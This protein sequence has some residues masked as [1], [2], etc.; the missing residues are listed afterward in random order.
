MAYINQFFAAA[1][2][3]AL[4]RVMYEAIIPGWDGVATGQLPADAPEISPAFAEFAQLQHR[5]TARQDWSTS[6]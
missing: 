5:M 6:T 4:S 3:F 2:T 1:D